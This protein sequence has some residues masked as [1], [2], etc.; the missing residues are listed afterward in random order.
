MAPN[1]NP[2]FVFFV[3]TVTFRTEKVSNMEILM[4]LHLSLDFKPGTGGIQDGLSL[5]LRSAASHSSGVHA[6][7]VAGASARWPMAMWHLSASVPRKSPLMLRFKA[8][9]VRG[10]MRSARILSALASGW[11][12]PGAAAAVVAMAT[13][14]APASLQLKCVPS[15]TRP[16]CPMH[17]GAS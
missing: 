9:N 17:P 7:P 5:E 16:G 15:G 1:V 4:L 12:T 11:H 14:P 8:T 13:V 10:R 2:E 6:P 3:I